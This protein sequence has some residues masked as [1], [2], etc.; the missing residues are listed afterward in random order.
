[1]GLV[2]FGLFIF[3]IALIVVMY[4]SLGMWLE[5]HGGVHRWQMW[6]MSVGLDVLVVGAIFA[7]V[8]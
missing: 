3:Y 8:E 6:L 4:I 7:L 2:I 5:G 1:M